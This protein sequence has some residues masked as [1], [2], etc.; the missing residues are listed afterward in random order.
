MSPGS[1]ETSSFAEGSADRLTDTTDR[2]TIMRSNTTSILLNEFTGLLMLAY[3]D[4]K[5]DR[6]DGACTYALGFII[7]LLIEMECLLI[8]V[9]RPRYS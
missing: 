3:E 9:I 1:S 2:T 4:L 5:F 6:V 8:I 7:H